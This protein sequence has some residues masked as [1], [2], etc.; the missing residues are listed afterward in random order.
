MIEKMTIFQ[1]ITP[2]ILRSRLKVFSK[3]SHKYGF[4]GNYLSWEDARRDS[5]G[6]DSGIILEKVKNSLLKVKNGEAVYERDSVLFDEIKYSW[7]LLATLLLIAGQ[8]G[9][10]LNI[11]DFGGSLGSTYYQNLKYLSNLNELKWNIVE[12]ESFVIC[13]KKFFEDQSLK[14]YYDINSCL[15]ETQPN[16]I[17]FS[18][19]FQYLEKPFEFLSDVLDIQFEY[20]LFDRTTFATNVNKNILTVQKVPPSI[21]EASYPCWL[22]NKEKFLEI[23]KDKYL[24]WEEF[25]SSL[26]LKEIINSRTEVTYQG[27]I[28]QKMM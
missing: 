23:F 28:F 22:F 19:S 20:I 12:Q 18:G 21:Y 3:H 5:I 11:I 27:F 6:Y 26:D 8:K 14:F 13:G 7:P 2:P 10:S 9:N 1:N 4:C 16:S 24:L 17:L 15:E 25:E